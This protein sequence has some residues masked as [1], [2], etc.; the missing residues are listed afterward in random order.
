MNLFNGFRI[1]PKK[2][3]SDTQDYALRELN[4]LSFAG[5]DLSGEPELEDMLVD[6]VVLSLMLRDRI[7]ADEIARLM[8]HQKK[9]AA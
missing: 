5:S 7:H 1:R 3:L 6:P 8:R 4:E 2:S 9:R